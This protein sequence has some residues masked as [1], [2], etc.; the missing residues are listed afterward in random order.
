MVERVG[1]DTLGLPGLVRRVGFRLREQ[2]LGRTVSEAA[3]RAEEVYASLR[4]ARAELTFGLRELDELRDT[5]AVVAATDRTGSRDETMECPYQGLAPYE[6]T[7]AERFH[8]REQL[9]AELLAR[10]AAARFVAVVGASGAG[11][12]SLVSA[13]LLPALRRGD[14]PGSEA[15]RAVVMAP[16]SRPVDAFVDAVSGLRTGSG[17][18][19]GSRLVLVVDQAEELFTSASAADRQRFLDMIT[20]AADR[21]DVT[22]WWSWSLAA[23][24]RSLV[25]HPGLAR[26]CPTPRWS[27]AR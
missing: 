23:T 27:R 4:E 7:D 14:L 20:A 25:E 19:T 8:G 26:R 15:W 1:A 12:S 17:E 22:M 21:A 3:I 10:L 9:V 24:S 16:G 5:E 6:A 11:E 18:P 13:G 2:Q